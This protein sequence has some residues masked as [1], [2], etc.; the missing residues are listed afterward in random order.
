V[1]AVWWRGQVV[2]ESMEEGRALEQMMQVA[3]ELCS[4]NSHRCAVLKRGAAS[5]FLYILLCFIF[6]LGG[7]KECLRSQLLVSC[8]YVWLLRV[9]GSWTYPQ[10]RGRG[11]EPVVRAAGQ[12]ALGE[13]RTQ[14]TWVCVC[15]CVCVC[16]THG[17]PT[18]PAGLPHAHTCGRVWWWRR[19]G[20]TW[21]LQGLRVSPVAHVRLMCVY[22]PLYLCVC[23]CVCAC[24]CVCV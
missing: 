20:W 5:F 12:A 4:R 10:A 16:V 9:C 19:M 11:A 8:T 1:C 17:T 24:V 21:T 13:R 2:L 6:K 22:L 14:G 15:V 18:Q 3:L 23:V 7:A